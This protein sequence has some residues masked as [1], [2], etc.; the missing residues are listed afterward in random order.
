[1]SR[2]FR[3]SDVAALSIGHLSHDIYSAFFSPLLPLLINRLGISISMAGILDF[4]RKSPAL[5]NPLVGYIVDRGAF[6][7]FVILTPAV[8][9]AAMSLIGSARNITVLIFLLFTAGLSS[10][11]F[12]VPTPVIIKTVSG[13]KIGTGM[14]FYMLGGEFSRTLGPLIITAA[15]SLWGMEGTWRLMPLGFVCSA[16]LFFKLRNIRI[17]RENISRRIDG[18]NI[19]KSFK[20]HFKLF[21]V[22]AMFLLFRTAMKSAFTIYLPTYLT[23]K[24]SSLW[25]AN[26]SLSVLQF[27]GAAGVLCAGTIS[28]RI[29]RKNT[30]LIS[31]VMTPVL[32]WV[33]ITADPRYSIPVLAAAGFF[34][35]APGPVILAVV[36][37]NDSDRPALIN[38]I[39]MTVSFFVTSLAIYLA[40]LSADLAGFDATYKYSVLLALVSLFFVFFMPEKTS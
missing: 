3:A 34:L 17:R 6:R 36:Q 7:Y 9:A 8:T 39:Y 28:D 5:I 33:F 29:G 38:S 12:H 11:F 26:I 27:S 18:V 2:K 21:F 31:S 4:V 37:D 23:Y 25:S 24:G 15:V 30:L 32:M 1:M 13:D 35:F 20:R 14:S 22:V 16:V 19:K 10:V 40:G